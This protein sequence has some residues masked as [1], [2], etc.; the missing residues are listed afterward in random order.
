MNL[1]L[2]NEEAT[3][4]RNLIAQLI[5]KSN[6]LEQ[7][8]KEA[9]SKIKIISME[10][11]FLKSVFYSTLHKK[12][13]FHELKS[14]TIKNKRYSRIYDQINS[15]NTVFKKSDGL[16]IV[17]VEM[18]AMK[19]QPADSRIK[20]MINEF[21]TANISELNTSQDCLFAKDKNFIA[22]AKYKSLT[23]DLHLTSNNIVKTNYA[24]IKARKHMNKNVVIKRIENTQAYFYENLQQL[25]N[26]RIKFYLQKNYGQSKDKN[27]TIKLSFDQ[28][29]IGKKH[30]LINFTFCLTN[31]GKKAQTASGNYTLGTL[32]HGSPIGI[33]TFFSELN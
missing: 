30:K 16:Q 6:A 21:P 3:S 28:T 14:R 18:A 2:A 7:A 1:S 24:T 12:R 20:L 29:Q 11:D 9:I 4:Q 33:F 19:R 23:T 22:D 13:P 26:E 32:K 8:N 15:M 27:I 25:M 5:I 10:R 17:K 31:E